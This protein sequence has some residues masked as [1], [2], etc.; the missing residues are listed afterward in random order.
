M[1]PN[2]Q[3]FIEAIKEK[4]KVCLRFYSKA[5]GEVIDLVCAPMDYGQGGGLRDG[6][7]RYWLWDYTR[8]TGSAVLGLLPNQVLDIRVL[9]LPFDPA[10]FGT[11]PPTWSVPRDWSLPSASALPSA[12]PVRTEKQPDSPAASHVVNN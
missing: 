11:P 2:H 7:N 5:D 6:I 9:G 1:I 4:K 12:G 8:N 10:E 3:Q